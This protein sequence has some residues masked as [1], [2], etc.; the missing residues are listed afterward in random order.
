MAAGSTYTPIATTTLGS[1]ASSV[2]FS[3]I[4]GSYTDLRLI[5]N[6]KNTTSTTDTKLQFNGDTSQN[7]A[8]LQ[9]YGDG[10]SAG[11]NYATSST[12]GQVGYFSTNWSVSTTDIMNYANTTTY[13][14]FLCRWNDSTGY[15]ALATTTWRST[16]AITS[17]TISTGANNF[18]T[19]STFT[20]YGIT[21]A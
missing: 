17:M 6:T 15:A 13:K 21:A 19:G 8:Y 2:T 18:D 16:S 14:P 10:S 5:I 9:L 3:S 12:F 1:A 20:L 11:S 4:S 7:Y